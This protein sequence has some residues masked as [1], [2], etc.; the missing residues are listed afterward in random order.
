MDPR[1]VTLEVRPDEPP[2]P[3]PVVLGVGRGVNPDEAAPFLDVP[4]EGGLL[5]VVQY[6]AGRGEKDDDVKRRK[7]CV[8][9][10]PGVL[11]GDNPP[12]M[13]GTEGPDGGNP[14]GDRVVTET[15]RPG[16]AEDAHSGWLRVGCVQRRG[17]GKRQ[18]ARDRTC[19]WRHDAQTTSTSEM[20][21][22]PHAAES[23]RRRAGGLSCH[24]GDEADRRRRGCHVVTSSG[25][26]RPGGRR[27]AKS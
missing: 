5:L 11:A 4:L 21:E 6:V 20:R 16:E 9:E 2:V 17:D 27:S 3:G 26:V 10:D 1:G 12:T 24:I 13:L 15:G 8:G 18:D 22:F 23:I 25:T 7:P 14:R 19:S